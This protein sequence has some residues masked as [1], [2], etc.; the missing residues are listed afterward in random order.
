MDPAGY[1]KI[2]GAFSPR[3]VGVSPRPDENGLF[4]G[5]ENV[6]FAE[7]ST[8]L[9]IARTLNALERAGV[10]HDPD[11]TTPGNSSAPQLR[12]MEGL[13]VGGS[14]IF[15]DTSYVRSQQEASNHQ[16]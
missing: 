16:P 7:V 9:G 1:D 13:S 8:N 4:D 6:R 14:L 3:S 11:S 2:V 15:E 5:Q 12:I 10:L